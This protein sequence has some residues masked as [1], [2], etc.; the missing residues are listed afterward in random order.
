[1]TFTLGLIALGGAAGAL[2]RY[3]NGRIWPHLPDEFPMGDFV[4]NLAGCLGMGLF[5]GVVSMLSSTPA[6]LAPLIATG[7]LGGLTTF[8]S[9]AA[10]AAGLID[11]GQVSKAV[12]YTGAT[13]CF[14]WLLLRLG[15]E[16]GRRGAPAD[17][18]RPEFGA[19]EMGD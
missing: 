9:Y 2:T 7:Y 10:D 18:G 11:A 17:A 19:T 4:A 1:M 14:G 8:S 3:T 6:R 15:W 12:F 13:V 5:L 16:L